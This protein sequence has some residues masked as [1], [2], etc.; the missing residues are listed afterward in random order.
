MCLFLHR[1]ASVRSRPALVRVWLVSVLAICPLLASAQVTGG[2]ATAAGDAPSSLA[3]A[4][5]QAWMRQPELSGLSLRRASARA[6]DAV[7][8][9]WTPEPTTVGLSD[10]SDRLL[11]NDGVREYELGIGIPLWLPGERTRAAALSRAESGS[12]ESALEAARLKLAGEVREAFWGWQRLRI[13]RVAAEDRLTNAR[14][15]AADV[16]RRVRAGD[17]ARADQNLADGAVSAA[18][19]QVADASA[20]LGEGEMRLTSLIGSPPSAAALANPEPVPDRSLTGSTI[21]HTHPEITDL[22]SR[23]E[24]SARAAELAAVRT[25]ASPELEITTTRERDARVS[26]YE[27]TVTIGIRVPLSSSGATSARQATA[28]AEAA[29][30]QARLDQRTQQLAFEQDSSRRSLDSARVRLEAAE[31]RLRLARET[32]GFYERSFRAGETDLPSR[33]RIESEAV[34]AQ[35]DAARSRIDVAIAVSRLR[36]SLGLLTE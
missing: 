7:A 10:R 17:L 27:Q 15:L 36:Q 30:A 1:P 29:E 12:L 6:T 18:A 13:D 24:V 28:R 4:F 32:R 21:A 5:R 25:R 23:A 26:R 35:R 33:L 2:E 19:F 11:A 14:S 31:Q 3:D 34:E 20:A 9:G 16:V 22:R 8:R